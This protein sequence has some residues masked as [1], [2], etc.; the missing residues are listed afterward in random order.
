[1][2]TIS[3][4]LW[5]KKKRKR[6]TLSINKSKGNYWGN[7]VKA[8]GSTHTLEHCSS[9]NSASKSNKKQITLN[10]SIHIRKY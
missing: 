10:S 7:T 4:D 9:L 1:M 5:L 6:Q 2:G 3:S 8:A